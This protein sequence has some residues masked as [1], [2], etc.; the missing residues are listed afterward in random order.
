[1]LSGFLPN[2]KVLYQEMK[3]C[4]WYLVTEAAAGYVSIVQYQL[5][6]YYF[7]KMCFM[8]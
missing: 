4:Q 7:A 5:S 3:T 6:A 2:R 8:T 1:M